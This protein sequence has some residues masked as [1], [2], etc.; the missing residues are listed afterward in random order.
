M[1]CTPHYHLIDLPSGRKIRTRK[2][3]ALGEDEELG[4]SLGKILKGALKVASPFSS[5]IPGGSIVTGMAGKLLGGGKKGSPAAQQAAQAATQIGISPEHLAASLAPVVGGLTQSDLHDIIN[6]PA[7]KNQ[8]LSALHEYHM[9]E[10]SGEKAASQITSSISPQ[11]NKILELSKRDALQKQITYEHNSKVK[12]S[13]RW[14]A[15]TSKQAKILA[16]LDALEK[17]L[18][19]NSIRNRAIGA[20]FGLPGNIL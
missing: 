13:D 16:K 19:A 18:D 1:K 20:S 4:F 7:L 8:L 11:L 14:K 6:S 15:N 17:R 9:Q 3:C 12:D 2:D 5:L 10:A